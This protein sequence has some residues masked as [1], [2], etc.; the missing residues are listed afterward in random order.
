MLQRGH[1][2]LLHPGMEVR[3]EPDHRELSMESGGQSV[4]LLEDLTHVCLDQKERETLIQY[5]RGRSGTCWV[6][7]GLQGTRR[8]PP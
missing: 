3:T 5:R 2:P 8:W 6:I 1:E 7:G 4:V